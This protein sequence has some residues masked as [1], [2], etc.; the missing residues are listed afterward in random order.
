MTKRVLRRSHIEKRNVTKQYLTILFYVVIMNVKTLYQ[1]RNDKSP[2]DSNDRKD[3]D[4]TSIA[5]RE[6]KCQQ[7]IFHVVTMN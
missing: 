3:M 2:N 6:T 4:I 5:Y 7:I 1:K